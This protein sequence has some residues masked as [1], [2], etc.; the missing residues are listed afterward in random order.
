MR[1]WRGNTWKQTVY[2]VNNIAYAGEQAPAL[3]VSGVR[4]LDD[5]R[6][7]V[8]FSTGEAK[9]FD[10]K[11]LFD[12]PIFAPLK[13]PETF[14]SVYIDYGVVTWNDGTIDIAP[15]TLYDE[16]EPVQDTMPA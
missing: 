10:C 14:R 4:P 15:E 13:T 2:I 12:L 9:I 16:G 5:F 1:S 3:R 6:L 8:R 7:W 11:P